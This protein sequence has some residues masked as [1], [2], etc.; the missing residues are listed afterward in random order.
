MID[1]GAIAEM[2]RAGTIA[3]DQT[4]DVALGRRLL[5][6][7]ALSGRLAGG[8]VRPVATRAAVY[9][10]DGN[11]GVWE[12]IP[13]ASLL[14]LSQCYDGVT[15]AGA[16]EIRMSAGRCKAVR[17]C[18]LTN[19][20]AMDPTFFDN[21]PQGVAFAN[22]FARVSAEGVTFADKSPANRA[23]SV[24]ACDYD[25]KAE[26]PTWLDTVNGVFRD[27]RDRDDKHKLLQE[28]VGACVVGIAANYA[29]CLVMIGDGE[30]GKSVIG[31]TIAELCFPPEAVCYIPPQS[32]VREYNLAQMTNA[33]LNLANELP[34]ADIQASDVFKTVI[35]G[36]TVV[37]RKPY[38]PP[39]QFRPKAGHIF[40]ANALP[41]TIDNSHGFWRRF[42]VVEFNRDFGK[43]P[44][45]VTKGEMKARLT[46]ERAG[47]VQWALWGAVRLLR[48]GKYTQPESHAAAISEWRLDVDP[49]AAFVDGCCKRTGDITPL[50]E[51]YPEYSRWCEKS[52]RR[53]A[54]DRTL[55]RRLKSLKIGVRKTRDGIGYGI[56]V[57]SEVMW[58]SGKGLDPQ[59]G[60]LS[61]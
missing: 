59:Q 1:I 23:T 48:Q 34:D 29:K 43:D 57:L 61:A 5:D 58:A 32:W 8:E 42:F 6:D 20:E 21:A 22:G 39:Y 50:K 16:K 19:P 4:S 38:E 28:F 46:A 36:G 24:V 52:G 40:L 14:A 26:C 9:R 17:D 3:K 7:I 33:R 18:A 54:S 2:I 45:R 27:D 47:I 44:A 53:P 51:I 30:N 55:G 10:Y 41:S 13:D 37:A 25:D 49:V 56:E 12:G 31:E 11:Q 15:V 35:D 60:E